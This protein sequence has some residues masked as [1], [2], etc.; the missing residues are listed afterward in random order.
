MKKNTNHAKKLLLS[1]FTMFLP[2]LASAHDFI[3]DYVFYCNV[4]SEENLTVEIT[5][6]GDSYD[7]HLYRYS[8]AITIPSTVTYEGVEYSVTSIGDHAFRGCENLT[9]ITIPESVTSIGEEAFTRCK[10][11]YKIVNNSTLSLS[12][13]SS[14]YGKVAYYA[15][16]VYQG[17]E[18]STV[19]GFQFHT[20]NGIHSL[21]NYIG[22]DTEIVLP[23]NYNGESYRIGDYAFYGCH[24]L[25]SIIIPEGV[26]SIGNSAFRETFITSIT[27]PEG[28][29]SIGN[30]A[31]RE[32]WIT[33]ITLSKGVTSIGE[34]AFYRC[35]DLN[36]IIIPEGVTSIETRAFSGCYLNSITIPESM[37][38]IAE[39]AFEGGSNYK[40]INYSP[41]NI[42]K[43]GSAYGYIAHKAE[44]V[45]QGS[46]L[47][48]VDGFQFYYN[49]LVNYIG[50]DTEIVLPDNYNGES[51]DLADWAFCGCINLKSI[52]IPDVV[53][54]IEESTF[55]KC[56][57]LEELTLGA[58]VKKIAENA[59]NG[60]EKLKKIFCYATRPATAERAIFSDRTYENA[61]LYVPQGCYDRYLVMTGWSDF[62]NIVEIDPTGVENA[63]VNDIKVQGHRGTLR[64]TGATKGEAISVY[65]TCGTLAAN[66]TAKDGETI[67]TLPEEQVYIVVVGDKVVK[68]SM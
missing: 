6:D 22:N 48:T 49:S 53:T 51:Y 38:S 24:Y 62:Y 37:T 21:V 54:S 30:S 29:T 68:I 57:G 63:N 12:E 42:S 59:F 43:G 27:I 14:D 2:L 50:N 9:S 41:L 60:C 3:A 10:K 46:E 64:I 20:S 4:T 13:G 25:D 52:T 23:D 16:V 19:D 45:Y 7:S 11:L 67:I 18:L 44:V 39:T 8:G 65:T 33:S 31:F 5:F 47:S 32:S 1:L 58:G 34:Y 15:K 66:K 28:V 17:S 56:E 26:T 36:S 55:M 40:I 35:D 61:T